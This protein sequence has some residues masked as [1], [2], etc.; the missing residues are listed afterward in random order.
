MKAVESISP[1]PVLPALAT[2]APSSKYKRTVDSPRFKRIQ[3]I[4]TAIM[5]GS[6]LGGLIAAILLDRFVHPVSGAALGIFLLFFFFVGMGL[7]IGYHRHFTHRSY[8]APT[9][10]RMGLGILG[11][12]AGQGPIVFWTALHRM[13]HELA[14]REG[15]PHSPNLHGPGAWNRLKGVYHA[16]VGWTVKHEVP[17]ANFYARDLLADQPIMWVNKRYYQWVLLGLALPAALGYLLTGTAYGALEGFLWGGLIRMFA[18]HNM[19]WWITSLA[20]V[21]GKRDYVGR[22]LSTNNFWVAIPTLGESWHNNHHAFPRAAILS[23][24]WW[25]IDISGGVL[26][27]LEKLGVVTEV[28]RVTPAERARR[29]LAPRGQA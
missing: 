8:K 14:D 10:F 29:T 3:H 2:G 5:T 18:L 24:H 6:G 7:T 13:H 16:Y 23:L 25:Q 21:L 4:H 15:D 26:V 9:A 17:N 20:H 28:C 19:I 27:V 12:M 22:D 1:A 11:S